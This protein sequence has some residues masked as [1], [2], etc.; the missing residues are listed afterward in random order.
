MPYKIQ[1][2]Y[3]SGWDDA[4]WTDEKDGKSITTRF[5]TVAQARTGLVEFVSE[6]SAAVVAGDMSLAHDLDDYRIVPVCS[7]LDEEQGL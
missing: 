3:S 1:M 7:L 4:G 5:Q 2:R 6:I